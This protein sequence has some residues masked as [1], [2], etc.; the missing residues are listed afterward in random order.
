MECKLKTIK[1]KNINLIKCFRLTIW[2]V[3]FVVVQGNV[4]KDVSF[5]LTI[6]NVNDNCYFTK[7]TVVIVLD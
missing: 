5:R 2:N 7:G 4:T 3:N 6:W 1:P